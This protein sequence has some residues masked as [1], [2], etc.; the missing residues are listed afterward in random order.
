MPHYHERTYNL[1]G[2]SPERVP[3]VAAHIAHVE[4]ALQAK[5]PAAVTE[6]LH[7]DPDG[8]LFRRLTHFPHY[9]VTRDTLARDVAQLHI[10][11]QDVRCVTVC[12]ENQ[13]VWAMMVRL[14][15]GDNPSVWISEEVWNER[16][17]EWHLHSHSFTDAILAFAWDFVVCDYPDY[18][19]RF[20]DV[21]QQ[22][23]TVSPDL[24][25]PTTYS[26]S[27]WFR[28]ATFWRRSVNGRLAT[29]MG[30]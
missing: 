16:I 18:R 3:E 15:E 27:A 28:A 10:S 4:A 21:V 5:I 2:R 30:E 24:D 6:W 13:G 29:F 1:L 26:V 23:P 22:P 11:G 20:I 12:A 14:D 8:A 9:S 25:G 7:Y 17:P 19:E